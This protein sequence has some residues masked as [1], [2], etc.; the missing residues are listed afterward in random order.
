MVGNP[1]I[2]LGSSR[3]DG[4]TMHAVEIALGGRKVP[5]I[6]LGDLN[7]SEYDYLGAN[8]GDDFRPLVERMIKHDPII[9]ATPIYWYAMSARMKK[10]I[11]RWTDLLERWQ[12]LGRGLR[13]KT[14]A[15][16]TAY[17]EHPDGRQ[18]FE[19]PFCLTASYM[20]MKFGGC[21]YYYSGDDEELRGGNEANA[22]EF[23]SRIFG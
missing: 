9:L 17:A 20:G 3:N 18:G 19:A 2:I 23:A 14:L 16:I 1:I 21:F 13:G 10:F 7:I 15:V 11:D 5:I 8:S 4:D 6:N 12:E 22:R